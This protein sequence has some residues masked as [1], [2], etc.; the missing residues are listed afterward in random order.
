MDTQTVNKV[1]NLVE[2]KNYYLRLRGDLEGRVHSTGELRISCH[3]DEGKRLLRH[4]LDYTN[5]R[6]TELDKEIKAL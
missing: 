6:L 3:S 4:L 1:I 2:S 5:S